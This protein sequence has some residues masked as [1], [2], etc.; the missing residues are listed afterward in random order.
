MSSEPTS[1]QGLAALVDLVTPGSGSPLDRLSRRVQQALGRV[2]DR[3]A[4]RGVVRLLRGNAW[5]GHPAH[6]L[7]IAVP[8]GA[9][10]VSAWYDLRSATTADAAQERVAD[11]ALGAGVVGAGMAAL[12]GVA[13]YLDTDGAA[14]R[15]TAVHAALNSLALGCYTASWLLRTQGRRQPGRRTAA[16]GLALVTVSGYLGGDL[17][18]RHG[19][20]VQSPT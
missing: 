1:G 17:A 18:Y 15:E 8:V 4:G 11:A 9:W 20:G 6:P 7:V 12:T 5:L 13:Q 16:A 14:R 3:P 10:V 2:A 19:V